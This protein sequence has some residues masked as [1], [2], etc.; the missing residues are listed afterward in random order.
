MSNRTAPQSGN[1]RAI[2]RLSAGVFRPYAPSLPEKLA[3]C[4]EFLDRPLARVSCTVAPAMK[5]TKK[6]TKP[7]PYAAQGERLRARR[8][9]LQ[10]KSA[11]AQDWAGLIKQLKA[12][13][14][15]ISVSGFQQWERGETWPTK[16]KRANLAKF[17]GWDDVE[18]EFGPQEAERRS[19]MFH[20]IS[21]REIEVIALYRALAADPN[22]QSEAIRYL[23]AKV[24]SIQMLSEHVNGPLRIV[25][26]DEVARHL[27][28]LP[29]PR[30]P[31]KPTKR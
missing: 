26:D 5:N 3:T 29:H 19:E 22:E 23:R 7:P 18:L 2:A 10:R 27:P 6:D 1:A 12:A 9:M 15:P 13:G 28:A 17:L 30:K 14:V 25:Q 11:I 31:T 24:A 4:K 16:T 21:Q 8:E 20:P